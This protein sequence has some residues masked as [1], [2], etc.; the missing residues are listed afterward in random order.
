MNRVECSRVGAL[1]L[2]IVSR[3]CSSSI[4]YMQPC[5]NNEHMCEARR[6]DSNTVTVQYYRCRHGVASL[7]LCPCLCP[8]LSSSAQLSIVSAT[9]VDGK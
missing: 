4:N 5:V 8:T 1:A 3:V 7:F 2:R 6:L 9:H